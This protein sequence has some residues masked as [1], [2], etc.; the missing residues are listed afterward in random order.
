MRITSLSKRIIRRIGLLILVMFILSLVVFFLA[1]LAP[2]DPLQSFYGDQLDSM[3]QEEIDALMEGRAGKGGRYNSVGV[4]NVQER[5]RMMYGEQYGIRYSSV[6]G[7]FTRVTVLLP[8]EYAQ[9]AE[10]EENV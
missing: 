6:K 10:V 9:T 1:R 5:I 4:Q 8:L 3:T 2:G 7:E